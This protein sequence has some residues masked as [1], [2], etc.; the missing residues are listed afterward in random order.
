M[1]KTLICCAVAVGLLLSTSCSRSVDTITV[2]SREDGSGTRGAFV[3]LVGIYDMVD[4]KTFDLTTTSA[5]I[6][7]NTAVMMTSVASDPSA[8]GYISLGSYN[9]MVKMVSINNILP[10]SQTIQSGEYPISRPFLI[11]TKENINPVTQD[12]INFILSTQGQEVVAE[13]GYVPV[14]DPQPYISQAPTGKIVVSGSSS[15]SPIMEALKEKYEQIN[16]QVTIELQ[17]NDSTTGMNSTV[18]NI[19]DIGMSSRDL[20]ESE[21][22]SGLIPTTIAMDGIAVI[23]NNDNPVS[24]LTLEQLQEIYMADITLWSQITGEEPSNK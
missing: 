5:E 24:N 2:I 10:S 6:T 13:K 23:V 9:D 15:V 4:G 20:K 19:C 18:N 8:I 3:D 11:A 21:L 17:Q 12:F 22:A 16:P 7:N 14:G 1:K